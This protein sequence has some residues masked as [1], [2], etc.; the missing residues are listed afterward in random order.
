ME[1]RLSFRNLVVVDTF[2]FLDTIAD[3]ALV[4][5]AEQGRLSRLLEPYMGYGRRI[6]LI[7]YQDQLRLRERLGRSSSVND[8]CILLTSIGMVTSQLISFWCVDR[9]TEG[10]FLH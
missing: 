3:W 4:F 6:P 9:K 2:Y 7:E 1:F 5:R 10:I 8:F